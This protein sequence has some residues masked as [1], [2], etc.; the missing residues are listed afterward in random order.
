MDDLLLSPVGPAIVLL[1]TGAILRVLP[2]ARRASILALVT[3]LPLAAAGLLL[4]RLRILQV[5]DLP[6]VWWPLV[7]SPLRVRWSLDGWNWLMVL[8]L[9]LVGA[10]A[11]LLTWRLPGLRASAFHGLSFL[12]LG[13]AVLTVVS[14]NLLTLSGAWV[15]TDV[16][17]I[18]RSR[19][20]RVPEG[21]VAGSLVAGG[22]LLMLLAVG[23]TGL[24]AVTASLTSA[25]L[26]AETIALLLLAAAL[27][28]AVYP[29][30]LWL[31][32]GKA[33]RSLGTQLLLGGVALI[34]GA[35]LLG[36]LYALGAAYWLSNPVWQPVLAVLVLAA[37]VAAWTSSGANRLVGLTA[38]R[39]GWIWLSLV[40]A[41]PAVGQDVLGWAL[42]T[43]VLG[44]ALLMVGMVIFEQWR[45][46]LP[47]VLAAALL[48][49][50]PLLA[51]FPARAWVLSG[52]L[53][54]WLFLVVGEGL[55]LSCVMAAWQIPAVP[56]K[57]DSSPGGSPLTGA[58]ASLEASMAPPGLTLRRAGIF[59]Q[60][61]VT[62]PLIRM[63]AAF[64][65]LTVPALIWGIWPELLAQLAGFGSS[66]S[67]VGYLRAMTLGQW[68]GIGL[69]LLLGFG[70]SRLLTQ[71]D[72]IISRWR[73]RLA[74]LVGLDW[75]S[76][77][78]LWLFAWLGDLTRPLMHVLEGEGYLGWAALVAL[79]IW[80][81]ARS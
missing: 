43:A 78:L 34:T 9:L 1:T 29:L 67:L 4:L 32:P 30:H 52:N 7:I 27:R 13:G 61:A 31:A 75:A 77:R 19:D 53:L 3:L 47:L 58:T 26:P 59:G 51:G 65:L 73:G 79:L 80:L 64:T 10:C 57:T 5:P 69:S 23:I 48:A 37:G 71:P 12:L 14:G 68:A 25:A 74:D 41:A 40:L 2:R 24:T 42:V 36:R 39:A 38:S 28:M 22:S 8:L 49:G 33:D 72:N 16:L 76:N 66:P 81:V 20:S 11:V 17:L 55:A 50:V 62:W 46:R 18:A 15:A 70:L 21:A 35:W 63:F 45:W 54:L 44:L 56:K 6:A 60:S